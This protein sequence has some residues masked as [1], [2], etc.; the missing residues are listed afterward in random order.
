MSIGLGNNGNDDDNNNNNNTEQ[1]M[2]KSFVHIRVRKSSLCPV[3]ASSR[4]QFGVCVC[5]NVQMSSHIRRPV[6][7]ILVSH[8][9]TDIDIDNVGHIVQLWHDD[10]NGFAIERRVI[11]NQ[12]SSSVARSHRAIH[13]TF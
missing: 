9:H 11:H 4:H 2:V 3:I 1:E 13:L 12:P 8:T 5:F 6:V 10:Q 7:C